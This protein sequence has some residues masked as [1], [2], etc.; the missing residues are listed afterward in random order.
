MI[1]AESSTLTKNMNAQKKP[2]QVLLWSQGRTACHLLERMLFSKQPNAKMLWH[3]FLQ[4]RRTQVPLFPEDSIARGI[5]EETRGEYHEAVHAG[6][7]EWEKALEEA[8]K[9]H[10]SNHSTKPSSSTNTPNSPST[11][12]KPYPT[13]TPKNQPSPPAS[14]P[15]NPTLIPSHLL[16]HPQTLPILTFRHPAYIIP[17]AFKFL[18]YNTSNSIHSSSSPNQAAEKS[19]MGISLVTSL[20]WQRKL[21]EFYKFHNIDPLVVESSSYQSSPT[22]VRKVC[23]LAGLD[24][25]AAVFEWDKMEEEDQE[26]LD[27]QVRYLMKTLNDSTGLRVELAKRGMGEGEDGEVDLEVLEGEWKREFGEEAA[28]FIRREVE[29]GLEDYAFLRERR[30][31]ED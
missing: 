8:E 16:L 5:P 2:T 30:V 23:K 28:G 1:M 27:P 18:V 25:E 21:Y 11:H 15:T 10:K 29:A 31:R 24:P 6:I 4:G 19:Y 12:N 20:H 13:S 9:E 26:K 14:T 17:S 22:F 3:P 7:K